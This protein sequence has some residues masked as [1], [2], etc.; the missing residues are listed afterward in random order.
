MA[1]RGSSDFVNL[2]LTEFLMVIIFLLIILLF[3]TFEQNEPVTTDVQ[4]SPQEIALIEANATRFTM[5][6]F[7][8]DTL[9]NA[10][11]KQIFQFIEKMNNA[12]D[13]PATQAIIQ[14]TPLPELWDTIEKVRREAVQLKQQ[15]HELTKVVKTLDDKKAIEKLVTEKIRLEG[16]L[17]QVQKELGRFD[18]LI[19]VFS[20]TSNQEAVTR[21]LTMHGQYKNLVKRADK[22]GIGSP[23]C[24]AEVGGEIEYLFSIAILESGMF[25]VT[26][27]YPDYREPDLRTIGYTTSK[28]PR[29]L[30]ES[31]F[32]ARM[33]AFWDY[34]QRRPDDCR[35]FVKVQDKTQTKQRW[36]HGLALVENYFYKAELP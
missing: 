2:T 6:F 8:E 9:Q 19:K 22:Q 11:E 4:L 28:E 10:T 31:Q 26:P 29:T 33:Q 13:N 34:G 17:G 24:W 25:H 30:T 32:K 14:E 36:K 35:F 21:A 3:Y 27:I 20:A 18:P 7:H 16:R 23:L 5:E 15:I 12:L 1:R